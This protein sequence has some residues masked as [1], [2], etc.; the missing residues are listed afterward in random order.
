LRFA[1]G[2]TYEDRESDSLDAD[3]DELVYYLVLGPAR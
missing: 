2:T 3:Y 1:R